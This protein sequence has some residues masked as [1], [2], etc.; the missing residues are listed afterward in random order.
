MTPADTVTA[1]PFA[2]GESTSAPPTVPP[3]L[4]DLKRKYFSLHDRAARFALLKDRPEPEAQ[5]LAYRAFHECGRVMSNMRDGN[6]LAYNLRQFWSER[7][8][9]DRAVRE[10][11]LERWTTACAGFLRPNPDVQREADALLRQAAAAGHVGARALGFDIAGEV[12]KATTQALARAIVESGDPLALFDG[13]MVMLRARRACDAGDRA[14]EDHIAWILAT[15]RLNDCYRTDLFFSETMC[16]LQG[17]CEQK[18]IETSYLNETR[19]DV[20][21]QQLLRRV[22]E[23]ERLMREG[24]KQDLLPCPGP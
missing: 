13:Y 12:D 3:T 23:L 8:V 19:S 1:P 14:T 22:D 17:A 18:T 15:C 11:A 20:D 2:R 10:A 9:S 24:R 16:A 4:D 7:N 6:D 21:R 5:Y